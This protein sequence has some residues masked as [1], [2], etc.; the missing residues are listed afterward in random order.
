MK[1]EDFLDNVFADPDV[2][3][4]LDEGSISALDEALYMF[5]NKSSTQKELDFYTHLYQLYITFL[6]TLLEGKN[7]DSYRNLLDDATYLILANFKGL[8]NVELYGKPDLR[9]G[10]L[11]LNNASVDINRCGILWRPAS[12]HYVNIKNNNTDSA[13]FP[14]YMMYEEDTIRHI[15][16]PDLTVEISSLYIM[17]GAISNS[18]PV[19]TLIL[20]NIDSLELSYVLSSTALKR[21][22][23]GASAFTPTADGKCYLDFRSLDDRMWLKLFDSSD[24]REIFLPKILGTQLRI[25]LPI[26]W[27]RFNNLTIY[28]AKGQQI[29]IRPSMREWAQQRIKSI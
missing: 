28:K 2:V 19:K 4:A 6:C 17:E 23:L 1:Y 3:D 9:R 14:T 10:P 21:I 8:D 11:C 24:S 15:F 12:I 22:Y 16:A 13:E 26:E 7:L 18:I 29:F 27:K 20:N 25:Q 5:Q